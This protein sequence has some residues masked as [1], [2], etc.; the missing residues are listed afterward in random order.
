MKNEAKTRDELIGEISRFSHLIE[1]RL[2]PDNGKT[3]DQLSIELGL[4]RDLLAKLPAAGSVT[5]IQKSEPSRI[6]E[7]CRQI[8][9][10]SPIAFSENDMSKLQSFFTSILHSGLSDF[11]WYF[12]HHP[13]AVAKC[14]ILV[15]RIYVN[16]ATLRLYGAV[17][18]EDFTDGLLSIFHEESYR[19]FREELIALAEGENSFEEETVVFTLQGERIEIYLKIMVVPGCEETLSRVIV[20][21]VDITDRKRAET[22]LVE[23]RETLDRLC[24]TIASDRKS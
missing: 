3:E 4:L 10:D 15:K 13:E 1:D 17:G 20:S 12:E 6:M 2:I 11:R 9:D 18:I 14:A 8:F 7:L 23:M 19:V 24:S 21:V 22:M 5:P 16:P